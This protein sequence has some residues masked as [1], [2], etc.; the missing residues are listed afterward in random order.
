MGRGKRPHS[1]NHRI[2]QPE[3]E[4]KIDSGPLELNATGL[5]HSF[6]NQQS[7]T[8][9]AAASAAAIAERNQVMLN[10]NKHRLS[11]DM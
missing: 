10:L 4:K 3:E 1:L 5:G 7:L 9:Q 6:R 2:Q 8:G 11:R